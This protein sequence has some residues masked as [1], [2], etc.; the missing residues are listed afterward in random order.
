MLFRSTLDRALDELDR[1]REREAAGIV[2]EMMRRSQA[3]DA[4]LDRI[5]ELRCGLTQ[6][7]AERLAQKLSELLKG[8]GLD[9]QRVLQEAALLAD[10]SDI[11]EEVQR[12]RAHNRQLRA[13]LASSGEL[14]KKL[15]FLLQEMNREANT[16]V[17]KTSGIG[18]SGLTI[19]DLGL[20]LKAEIEKIREQGMNLE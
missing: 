5:E 20:S 17:S 7:L 16:T 11:S 19:T 14:G 4:G 15:D 9:P 6:S 18:E 3:I 2:E 13:L 8:I 12:L 10:R 1:A